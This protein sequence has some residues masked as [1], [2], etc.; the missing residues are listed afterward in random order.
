[1]LT[2]SQPVSDQPTREVLEDGGRRVSL[3]TK[4][5]SR[6]Y[7]PDLRGFPVRRRHL[8]TSQT[9]MSGHSPTSKQWQ[10]FRCWSQFLRTHGTQMSLHQNDKGRRPWWQEREC[11]WSEATAS[12]VKPGAGLSAVALAFTAVSGRADSHLLMSSLLREATGWRQRWRGGKSVGSDTAK[13]QRERGVWVDGGEITSS[14]PVRLIWTQQGSEPGCSDV[15][16]DEEICMV[17]FK[18]TS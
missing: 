12:S 1:M 2:R 16:R 7:D 3:S 8:E 18:N 17:N 4:T 15:V 10:W 13:C 11:L 14:D 6:V 9:E 5:R